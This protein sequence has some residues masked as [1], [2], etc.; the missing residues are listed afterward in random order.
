MLRLW[1]LSIFAG[2][3]GIPELNSS[4]RIWAVIAFLFSA[5]VLASYPVSGVSQWVS[6]YVK[7]TL[8]IRLG[9]KY[10]HRLAPDEKVILGQFL[11]AGGSSQVFNIADGRVASLE[12]KGILF[13]LTTIALV[14]GAFYYSLQ[15]WALDYVKEHPKLVKSLDS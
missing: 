14:N 15:P 7:D 4:Y 2:P 9:K 1:R 12:A 13:R 3:F 11:E 8:R 10:L 6:A 5:V